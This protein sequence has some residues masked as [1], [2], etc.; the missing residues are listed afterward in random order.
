MSCILNQNLELPCFDGVGGIKELYIGNWIGGA[1][2]FTVT[3]WLITSFTKPS[4]YLMFTF[5]QPS[6]VAEWTSTTETSIEN[7]TTFHTQKIG[8]TFYKMSAET[9]ELVNTLCTGRFLI[10][11][12]DNNGKYWLLG[13]DFGA[14]CKAMAGGANRMM[15]D[16]N[17]FRLEFESKEKHVPY[18][19]DAS[20]FASFWRSDL[21]YE[22]T[23]APQMRIEFQTATDPITLGRYAYQYRG[24][25]PTPFI[26][27]AGLKSIPLPFTAPIMRYN[28]LSH[29]LAGSSSNIA[30][31]TSVGANDAIFLSYSAS[32]APM[33]PL[34]A[35]DK[36]LVYWPYVSGTH[37]PYFTDNNDN[38]AFE[39]PVL[40]FHPST[41]ELLF[42]GQSSLVMAVYTRNSSSITF[43]LTHIAN[44]TA[45]AE[46]GSPSFTWTIPTGS[47]VAYPSDPANSILWTVP[48]GVHTIGLTTNWFVG[49]SATI[50]RSYRSMVIT[51]F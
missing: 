49:V 45:I 35:L 22:V 8:M 1:L 31:V 24:T 21:D 13:Y 23:L 19:V 39:I 4:D 5:A 26:A 29:Y 25:T 30:T 44:T 7:A 50:P 16:L 11:V 14:Y 41:Q 20:A 37:T 43:L 47:Y 40:V 42:Y 9:N 10:I 33:L 3:D 36:V 27:T 12:L 48:T 6:E 51:V 17:G 18:E 38:T 46:F 34:S 28:K 2:T 15:G 32:V